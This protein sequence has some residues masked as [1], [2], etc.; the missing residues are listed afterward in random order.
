MLQIIGITAT[1][2]LIYMSV[3]YFIALALKD[4]SIADIGWGMG[5]G[6]AGLTNYF[7]SPAPSLRFGL[8][9]ILII[10]WGLR[11]SSYI[12]LR[13]RGKGED[14]R[15]RQWRRDWGQSWKIRSFLQVFM[16]QGLL[17]LCIFSPVFLLHQDIGSALNGWDAIGIFVWLSGFLFESIADGQLMR[18]KAQPQNKGKIMT[19]GLWHFSRHPNYFGEALLWWGIGLIAFNLPNGWFAFLGPFILTF[20]L[21]RISGVPML[22]KKYADNPAYQK[23]VTQTNVFFPW[24]RRVT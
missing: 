9:M 10:I 14:F 12:Y 18:F 8:V 5:F 11:L 16:L 3:L 17:L 19:S 20:L 22:E 6:I 4:N 24:F 7:W 13:G 1:V 23:Y 2:I 15:Y 21:L